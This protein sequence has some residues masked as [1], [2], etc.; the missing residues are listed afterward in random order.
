MGT[1]GVGKQPQGSY[2]GTAVSNEA[3]TLQGYGDGALTFEGRLF[4]EGSFFD[5]ENGML[6]RMRLFVLPDRRLVYSIVSGAASVNDRR[7]YVLQVEDDICRMDNGRQS[8]ALPV[9]ML[10][11]AVFGLCGLES[12]QEDELRV[13]LQD[14]LRIVGA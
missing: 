3:F 4:S 14:S 12:G 6:T 1:Q 7:V 13:T 8:V 10:F 2:A 5:K 11:T 9:D